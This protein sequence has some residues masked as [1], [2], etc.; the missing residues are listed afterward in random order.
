M[1]PTGAA[2]LGAL[3]TLTPGTTVI[4]IDLQQRKMLL[5]LLDTR[6]LETAITTIRRDFEA[7]IGTLF[8]PEEP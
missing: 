3:V 2:V 4:D 5:H 7:D 8:P 1:S 6:D